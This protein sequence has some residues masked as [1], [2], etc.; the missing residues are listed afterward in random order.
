MSEIYT[1]LVLKQALLPCCKTC[2]QNQGAYVAW[3]LRLACITGALSAKR[4]ERS[5]LCE[6]RDEGEVRDE[7]RRKIKRLLP[8]HCS[9]SS[10]I[11]YLNVVFQ[12]VNWWR[13]VL[14]CLSGT[15]L[16]S[17]I[18]V[19]LMMLFEK[20]FIYFQIFQKKKKDKQKSFFNLLL[21]RKDVLGLLPT[22]LGK[23]LIDLLTFL[24]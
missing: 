21:K 17:Q 6:A 16:P 2:N 14:A 22:R 3:S 8:V 10:H 18:H 23:S 19:L 24:N 4:G 5:I 20:P 1:W 13:F 11:H 12:L 9:G 7:G 15:K